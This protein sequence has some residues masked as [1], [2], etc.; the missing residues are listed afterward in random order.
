M[1]DYESESRGYDGKFST[2]FCCSDV[3]RLPLSFPSPGNVAG[4][5]RWLSTPGSLE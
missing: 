4:L 2:L 5:S 1:M 3:D